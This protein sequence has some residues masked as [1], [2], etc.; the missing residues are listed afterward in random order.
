MPALTSQVVSL[1]LE[2]EL[3][4][5]SDQLKSGLVS[6]SSGNNFNNYEMDFVESFKAELHRIEDA[7]TAVGRDIES[8]ARALLLRASAFQ[9]EESKSCTSATIAVLKT[10]VQALSKRSRDLYSQMKIDADELLSIANMAD[11]KLGNYGIDVK[12]SAMTKRQFQDC[13]PWKILNFN[14]PGIIAILLSDISTVVHYLEMKSDKGLRENQWV[15]STS[16]ERVTTK[17][18]VDDKD[19]CQVILN[20]V[21]ELPLLVYVSMLCLL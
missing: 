17:Y 15:S 11:L 1:Y 4:Q 13:H 18:W 2:N 19:L 12:L 9:S 16:F 8:N 6:I 21:S 10:Q 20:S 14:D 5:V 7:L 3:D